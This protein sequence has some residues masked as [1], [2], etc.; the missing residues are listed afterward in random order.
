ML[1]GH[2]P[3]TGCEAT[4]GGAPGAATLGWPRQ[5]GGEAVRPLLAELTV[6]AAPGARVAWLGVAP[7]AL[8]RYR[9][10]GL[11]RGDLQ[12]V[13]EPAEADL[14]V[15]ALGAG[16]RAAEL[17]AWAALGSARAQAGVYQHEV[18]LAQLFARPGAWR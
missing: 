13:A 9:A 10:A 15:V 1:P 5:D 12:E 8:A 2:K 7:G 3:I 4:L 17:A 11:L 18:A 14:V 6:H 16:P